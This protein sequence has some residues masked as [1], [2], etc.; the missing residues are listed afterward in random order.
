MGRKQFN[1]SGVVTQGS[2]ASGMY[3]EDKFTIHVDSYTKEDLERIML[4]YN[5]KYDN[6]VW[7]DISDS[8]GQPH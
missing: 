6:I 4:V 8:G 3:C 2:R 1:N 5:E 7:G